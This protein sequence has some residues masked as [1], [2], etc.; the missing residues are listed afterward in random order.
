MRVGSGVGGGARAVGGGG[1]E[2]SEGVGWG[3]G[4]A[5]GVAARV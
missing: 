3:G 4:V 5:T 1:A 2:A